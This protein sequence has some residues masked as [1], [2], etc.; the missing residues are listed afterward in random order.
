MYDDWNNTDVCLSLSGNYKI[1]A[2]FKNSGQ[3]VENNW[4]F[5]VA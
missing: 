3:F 1:Y 5:E 2:R 4:E